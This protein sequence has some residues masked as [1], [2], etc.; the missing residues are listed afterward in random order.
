ME[1]ISE[2]FEIITVFC[3]VNK[4]LLHGFLINMK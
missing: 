1:I 3:V 4:V 2:A